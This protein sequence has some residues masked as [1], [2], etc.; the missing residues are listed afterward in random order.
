MKR[1]KKSAKDSKASSS[2]TGGHQQG[3]LEPEYD[4]DIEDVEGDEDDL[5]SPKWQLPNHS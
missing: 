1:T 5:S 4:I 2:S 3:D